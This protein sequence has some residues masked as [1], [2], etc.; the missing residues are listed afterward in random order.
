MPQN[1]L[2]ELLQELRSLFAYYR[3]IGLE[4]LPATQALQRF[5]TTKS[6]SG[7]TDGKTS[8]RSVPRN[9]LSPDSNPSSTRNPTTVLN[10]IQSGLSTCTR[11]ILHTDRLRIIAGRGS[12][13]A[14]LFIVG[15]YPGEDGQKGPFSDQAKDLLARMLQAIGLTLEEVYL[16]NAI[17]CALAGDKKPAA[18]SV[19]CCSPYLLREIEA[20]SPKVICAMGPLATEALLHSKTPFHR[21][22][23]RS[24]NFN[25]IQLVPT[26]HPAFLLKNTEMKK[27]AWQDLQL[28]QKILTSFDN[29]F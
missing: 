5:L 14:D 2:P 4:E 3:T 1:H 9:A 24:H 26:F 21:L 23:G 29:S 6:V 12:T 16:T 22:R 20:V 7:S 13:N 17:K 10:D 25:G 18:D 28:I 8:K 27:D 19:L 15:E 11:C